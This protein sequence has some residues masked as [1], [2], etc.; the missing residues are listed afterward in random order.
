MVLRNH[1]ASPGSLPAY[2][3]LDAFLCPDPIAVSDVVP[4]YQKKY[5]DLEESLCP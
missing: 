1:I 5:N 4:I 3:S 2:F